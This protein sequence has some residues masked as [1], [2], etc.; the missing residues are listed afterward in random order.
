[1]VGV[2]DSVSRL[3][4]LCRFEA[5]SRLPGRGLGKDINF[6]SDSARQSSVKLRHILSALRRACRSEFADPPLTTDVPFDWGPLESSM[7]ANVRASVA[8]A[9]SAL[10][11]SL[12]RIGFAFSSAEWSKGRIW[13]I[14]LFCSGSGGGVVAFRPCFG[15]DDMVV[16]V[17][18]AVRGL[19]PDACCDIAAADDV[20]NFP[21]SSNL[22]I[23]DFR[24]SSSSQTVEG[25]VVDKV[26]SVPSNR[27]FSA[28]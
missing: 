20:G 17:V 13:L 25:A 12:L 3:S 26:D 4:V 2:V 10:N 8:V 28:S 23:L 7:F 22:R 21:V 9:S 19:S 14:A 18:V 24:S 27:D 11:T 1:M 5:V 6:S 15:D 16:T